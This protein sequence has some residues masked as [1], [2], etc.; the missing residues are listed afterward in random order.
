[1]SVGD[2]RL[3]LL[4]AAIEESADT[5]ISLLVSTREAAFRGWTHGARL[6]SQQARTVL[7]ELL[8]QTQEAESVAERL[9]KREA[10][11]V[12]VQEHRVAQ[13]AQYQD[14]RRKRA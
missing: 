4:H 6:H 8:R 11:A 14:E 5:A 7:I 12:A 10:T 1:M 9:R 2:A 13:A 3:A